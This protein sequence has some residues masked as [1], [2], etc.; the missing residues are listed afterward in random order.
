MM[1]K[2]LGILVVGQDIL[3]SNGEVGINLAYFDTE[4]W[5]VTFLLLDSSET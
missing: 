5:N 1:A 2:K 4:V 3:K